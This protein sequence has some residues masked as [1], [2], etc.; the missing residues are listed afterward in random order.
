MESLLKDACGVYV[1]VGG[2]W[3]KE[4]V[5]QVGRVGVASLQLAKE[6]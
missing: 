1:P 2:Y 5:G 6:V 3:M 4:I